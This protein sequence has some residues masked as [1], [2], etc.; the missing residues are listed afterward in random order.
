MRTPLIFLLNALWWISCLPAWFRFRMATRRPRRAQEQALRR[1]TRLRGAP[2]EARAYPGFSRYPLTDYEDYR[3]KIEAIRSGKRC[4]LTPRPTLL[5]EPTSGSRGGRKLIP[6]TAELR[7]EFQAALGA[8]IGDV[9]IR[10]PVLLRSTQYWAISPSTVPRESATAGAVPVGFAADGDYLPGWQRFAA[11]KLLAVPPEV[12]TISDPEMAEV[13]TVLC[14]LRDDRLGLISVWHPSFLRLLLRRAVNER[15]RLVQAIHDGGSPAGIDLPGPLKR[16]LEKRFCP[17]PGR[18]RRVN[19][20]LAGDSPDWRAI[21]PRLRV[22]SCWADGRAGREA[23][24]LLKQFPG[25]AMQPKGLLATEGVV[26]IPWGKDQRRVCVPNGHFLEFEDAADGSVH[27]L[28]E[29]VEGR[30]YTVILTTGNGFCRYRLGDRVSVTG[31]AGATPCL[32]FLGRAGAVVDVVGEKLHAGEVERALKT[33]EDQCGAVFEFAVLAPRRDPSG[34]GYVLYT[35]GAAIV[36]GESFA[37]RFDEE[38]SANYHY[39]HARH[40][41]QLS[42]LQ[43]RR[44]EH[45]AARYRQ[46]LAVGGTRLGDVKF[47]VLR[48]EDDWEDVFTV[49]GG[50]PRASA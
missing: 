3:E 5:L 24:E 40:L 31:F 10:Y 26:T 49:K 33:C 6:Y 4:G 38:L 48:P 44:V 36:D 7:R 16:R 15:E 9:Y 8:W 13:I 25:V 19:Q 14:L 29:L 35:E 17:R 22:M 46:R 34:W 21:W 27:P 41:G 2:R 42:P 32:E 45:G 47:S 43:L 11:G 18:A 50:E 20:A 12:G 23:A 30:E 39:R 28:W 37:A 1:Q